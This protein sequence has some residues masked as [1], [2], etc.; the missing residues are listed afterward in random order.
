MGGI[1]EG[2]Q[3]FCAVIIVIVDFSPCVHALRRVEVV[4]KL[5]WNVYRVR[6]GMKL[7]SMMLQA[8]LHSEIC[9][10]HE[11]IKGAAL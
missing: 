3:D 9:S 10:Q 5:V 4:G 8:K 11:H 2:S 6:S 1:P 7:G